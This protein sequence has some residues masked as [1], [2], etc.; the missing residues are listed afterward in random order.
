MSGDVSVYCPPPELH[1][2]TMRLAHRRWRGRCGTTLVQPHRLMELLPCIA[3]TSPDTMA[4]SI[5]T[6]SVA[7]ARCRPGCIN[8]LQSVL[9]ARVDEEMLLCPVKRAALAVLWASYNV[10][11]SG[12]SV[13]SS[14]GEAAGLQGRH[15]WRLILP[16]SAR[17]S[18]VTYQTVIAVRYPDLVHIDSGAVSYGMFFAR[19]SPS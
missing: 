11:E 6:L 7:Q 14:L 3:E 18:L 2:L 17:V 5:M 13:A 15:Q 1:V 9:Q 19:F 10:Q 4:R 16:S 12:L 8:E